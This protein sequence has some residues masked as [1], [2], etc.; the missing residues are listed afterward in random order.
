MYTVHGCYFFLVLAQKEIEISFLGL[1]MVI[2]CKGL[3]H[4]TILFSKFSFLLA[5]L[6]LNG[7]PVYP[8]KQP[9][10]M[11]HNPKVITLLKTGSVDSMH[12]IHHPGRIK[13]CVSQIKIW[14]ESKPHI[15]A[16]TMLFL[17]LMQCTLVNI[18][19]Y[20]SPVNL[21]LYN[22]PS[23]ISP[24]FLRAA[25]CLFKSTITRRMLFLKNQ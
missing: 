21:N 23:T 4:V 25:F 14:L 2:Q 9:V 20:P 10:G 8:I 22:F 11:G 19:I 5:N 6:Y 17:S 18:L 7:Q 16:V 24:W 3:L 1:V 15:L 12:K 13:A